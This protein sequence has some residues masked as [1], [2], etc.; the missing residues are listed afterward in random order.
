MPVKIEVE[1]DKCLVESEH[2]TWDTLDAAL[3]CESATVHPFDGWRLNGEDDDERADDDVYDVLC[4]TCREEEE[5]ARK[6]AEAKD[7]GAK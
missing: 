3:E 1:C 7:K 5:N 4:P 6:T 2:A